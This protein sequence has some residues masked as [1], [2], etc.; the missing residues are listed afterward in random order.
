VKAERE[1]TG[2]FSPEPPELGGFEAPGW[3]HD[4]SLVAFRIPGVS[5]DSTSASLLRRLQQPHEQAA[6]QRF[7]DL[8]AP[9]IFHWGRN[10]GLTTA[11][12]SDLTQDVLA[13]L[14]DKLPEFQYDPSRRFRGWLRTIT[15][16][17]ANDLHRR[18]AARPVTGLDET[19]QHVSVASDVDLFAE[20]EYR[21][22][23]IRR[24]LR[25]MQS[26]FQEETWQACWRVVV[27]EE[28]VPEVAQSLGISPNAVRVAKCRVLKR[29]REELRGL[30]E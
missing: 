19:A 26:E 10:H 12:A 1:V 29:L 17:R 4:G 13:T 21:R 15:V 24:A 28:P 3:Y 14:I 18:N 8:Y 25:V 30:L 9:L 20:Q 6:W 2:V 22:H 7:V 5:M 27:D 11:D 16:N 23:L